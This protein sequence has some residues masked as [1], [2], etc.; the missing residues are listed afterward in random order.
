MG[1]AQPVCAALQSRSFLARTRLPPLHSSAEPCSPTEAEKSIVVLPGQPEASPASHPSC[2][3]DHFQILTPPLAA[4]GPHPWPPRCSRA[5][6]APFLQPQ[7]PP[8]TCSPHPL[9]FSRVRPTGS[10]SSRI[11]AAGCCLSPDPSLQPP[12]SCILLARPLLL[13]PKPTLKPQPV[14]QHARISPS[15]VSSANVTGSSPS[16]T[17][18]LMETPKR[19]RP[20]TDPCARHWGTEQLQP[21]ILYFLLH[22]SSLLQISLSCLN[23]TGSQNR[24]GA[25]QPWGFGACGARRGAH[26]I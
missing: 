19:S 14:P 6:A 10:C 17:V 24:P 12:G 3:E 23:V 18:L 2:H 9:N 25:S 5:H 1:A 22:F 4:G 7:Q 11:P 16:I 15:L 26:R 13:F 21:F 8:G 20:R